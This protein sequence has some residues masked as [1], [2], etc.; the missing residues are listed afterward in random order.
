MGCS[1]YQ[2]R[3][4]LLKRVLIIS[5]NPFTNCSI[6]TSI[7]MLKNNKRSCIIHPFDSIATS[8]RLI[9]SKHVL[10]VMCFKCV[11]KIVTIKYSSQIAIYIQADTRKTA[12][13]SS[14]F[15]LLVTIHQ[16][17][18]WLFYRRRVFAFHHFYFNL[19]IVCC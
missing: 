11:G 4:S 9:F 12:C 17:R 6:T 7:R 13:L 3:L 19:N 16:R 15:S 14:F 10:Q 2:Y 1:S 5:T 8:H 18:H